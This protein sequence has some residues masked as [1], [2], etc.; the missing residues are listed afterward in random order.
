MLK[1]RLPALCLMWSL[2]VFAELN[3]QLLADNCLTCHQDHSASER[4]IPLLAGLPAQKIQQDLLDFKYGRKP[5][6]LMPRIAKGF[7]DDDLRLIADYL[8]RD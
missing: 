7:S 1:R 5:A 4:D 6:T 8:A 2:P 3:P